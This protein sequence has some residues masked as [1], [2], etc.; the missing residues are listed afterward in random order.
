[1]KTFV[2]GSWPTRISLQESIR[3][4]VSEESIKL[5]VRNYTADP[6]FLSCLNVWGIE[7]FPNS[8]TCFA[9]LG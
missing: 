7:I 4:F 9:E 5:N 8:S 1:M 3:R 2:K 6:S